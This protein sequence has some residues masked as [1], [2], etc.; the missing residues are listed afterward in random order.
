VRDLD[1]ALRRLPLDQREAVLLVGLEGLSYAQA[2][3][4]LAI[5]LGTLMSRLS[6]GR[7]RLRTMV[8]GT[9]AGRA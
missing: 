9:T 1:L 3:E 7:E 5:P 2:A 6:R 8:A 4:A